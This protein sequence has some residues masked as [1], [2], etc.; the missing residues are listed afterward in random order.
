LRRAAQLDDAGAAQA[1]E[2]LVRRRVLREVGERFA[3][4]H[5]RIL[6]CVADEILLARRSVLHRQT[7]AAIEELYADDLKPYHVSLGLHYREA[8]VWDRAL[9]HWCAA[10][11]TAMSQCAFR[12]AARCFEQA[13]AVSRELPSGQVPIADEIDLRLDLRFARHALG[14]FQSALESLVE[15]EGLAR[16]AND[17]RR[18]A[19][20]SACLCHHW[21]IHQDPSRARDYGE[22]AV[23]VGASLNEVEVVA[24]AEIYLGKAAGAAGD[25]VEAAARLRRATELF[26][27]NRSRQRGRWLWFPAIHSRVHLA[28][29]LAELGEFHEGIDRGREAIALAEELDHAYSLGLACLGLGVLLEQ[30]GDVAEGTA[31]LERGVAVSKEWELGAL[32]HNLVE[33]LG[34]ARA[35]SGRAAEGVAMLQS[36]AQECDRI[37]HLTPAPMLFRW[38]EACILAGQM[39][40]A[41]QLIRRAQAGNRS[42]SG[43]VKAG[44]L[45]GQVQRRRDASD[46]AVARQYLE[47]ARE[48]AEAL[49]MRPLV[50]RCWLELGQLHLQSGAGP[51]AID[52]L[53]TAA[54][55]LRRMQMP[56][57]LEEAERALEH[58]AGA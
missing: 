36:A 48:G 56:L 15:A 52:E 35:R 34:V 14:D 49:Q 28:V 12:E 22:R 44:F 27:G 24:T 31:V 23:A 6:V 10:G 55:M 8:A 5:E 17:A 11:R 40:E 3:F 25:Y 32:R 29:A 33:N 4:T 58:R 43:A 50:A 45:L 39:E 54:E 21:W 57:W 51:R 7:A 37:R 19:M 42:R 38:A 2:E 18:L 13:L 16:E 9:T 1:L 46:A 53:E 26:L 30:K 41:L 20:A 47:R